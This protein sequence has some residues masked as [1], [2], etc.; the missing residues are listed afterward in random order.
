MHDVDGPLR[1][2]YEGAVNRLAGPLGNRE[3]LQ[4]GIELIDAEAPDGDAEALAVAAAALATTGLPDVRLDVG[5]VAPAH[6]VLGAIANGDLEARR[7][8]YLALSRKDKV[9]VARAASGLP[10]AVA[11]IAAELP[12][13]WGSADEVLARA[14]ALPW[15]REVRSGIDTLEEVLDRAR[16]LIDPALHAGITVDLGEVRG[17]EYYT[18]LRFAGYAAG[19]GD[20]VVLGGRYDEL[21]GR[22]GRA[23]HATGFAVDIEAIAQAQSA[24][25]IEP[26]PGA[27]A[28]LVMAPRQGRRD[29]AKVAA[30]LRVHGIR[31]AVDLGGS[32]SH[33]QVTAYGKGVGFDHVIELS[34]GGG[35]RVLATADGAAGAVLKV[36]AAA[37]RSAL[38]GDALPLLSALGVSDL[39]SSTEPDQAS[40]A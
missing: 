2:C 22:Y 20:A 27:T 28:V 32:R 9:G 26:P 5:H 18:G 13:L 14:R 39:E 8:L 12:S 25:G 19:A 10:V 6:F 4:A 21:V 16:D 29:A 37:V 38:A 35:A 31:A 11:R 30:A 40:R 36:S 34:A 15:P 1:L 24:A 33:G 17:H 7:R 3:I 23:A